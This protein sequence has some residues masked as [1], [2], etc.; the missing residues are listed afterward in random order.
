M[1]T[2]AGS[3]LVSFFFWF[4]DRKDP[5]RTAL[6]LAFSRAFD[7]PRVAQEMHDGDHAPRLKPRRDDVG[8]RQF[9]ARE[10]AECGHR[11]VK[12]SLVFV[13]DRTEERYERCGRR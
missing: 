10:R 5:A 1:R 3:L 6:K 4:S 11:G 9:S 13:A 8:N 12:V 7:R 2:A